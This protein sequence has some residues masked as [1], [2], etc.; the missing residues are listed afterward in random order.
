MEELAWL[1]VV[2]LALHAEL[3]E[4][5]HEDVSGGLMGQ[6]KTLCSLCQGVY[7]IG[8]RWD[9]EEWCK[10]CCTSTAKKG[11]AHH[12]CVLSDHGVGGGGYC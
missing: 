3:L 2:P 1:L 11:T 8:M 9:V 4:E 5:T 12:T 10:L 7:W 6:K